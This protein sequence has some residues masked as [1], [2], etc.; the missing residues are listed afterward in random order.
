MAA[1]LHSLDGYFSVASMRCAGVRGGVTKSF[2]NAISCFICSFSLAQIFHISISTQHVSSIEQI[3]ILLHTLNVGMLHIILIIF[4]FIHTAIIAVTSCHVL[5]FN[6]HVVH[7]L[8]TFGSLLL[9]FH[10]TV[11]GEMPLAL[12]VGA[13]DSWLGSCSGASSL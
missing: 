3:I 12:A 2:H 5:L 9:C 6:F 13:D 10:P 4:C 11:A 7:L 1:L 8:G